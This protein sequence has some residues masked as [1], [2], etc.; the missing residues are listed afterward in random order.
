[1][2]TGKCHFCGGTI[3]RDRV[4]FRDECDHCGRPLHA[5]VQCRHY[6]P[7]K[8]HDCNEP[9]IEP[10]YDKEAA[11]RCDWFQFGGSTDRALSRSD[12]DRLLQE[13]LKKGG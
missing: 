7:G 8:P 1:M 12:A 13:L 2:I 10:V 9:N 11:N 6:A 3:E 5:C 4:T